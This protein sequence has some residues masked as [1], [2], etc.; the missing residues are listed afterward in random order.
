M[1][2]IALLVVGLIDAIQIVQHW[3]NQNMETSLDFVSKA[4]L[5]SVCLTSVT[6]LLF[7]F[8][9]HFQRKHGFINSGANWLYLL[10]LLVFNTLAIFFSQDYRSKDRMIYIYIQYSLQI[11]LFLLC[12]FPERVANIEQLVFSANENDQLSWKSFQINNEKNFKLNKTN[13]CPKETASV[14]SKLTFWWF[15]AL[16]FKGWKRPLTEEDLWDLPVWNRSSYLFQEFN[17]LWKHGSFCNNLA[18]ETSNQSRNR[19]LN[20]W[21]V[22]VKLFLFYFLLPSFARLATDLLQLANPIVLK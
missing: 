4:R 10:L 15:N 19:S 1:A 11:F 2:A 9:L 22:F 17:K 21:I 6:Y 14:P 7:I 3:L 8:N 13:I 16:I 5:L 18:R 20:L 12:S